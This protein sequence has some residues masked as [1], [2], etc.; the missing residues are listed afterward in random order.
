MR[1]LCP[2]FPPIPLLLGHPISRA[3]VRKIKRLILV[4]PQT[5][6]VYS[7]YNDPLV[8]KVPS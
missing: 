5:R 2:L 1:P 7:L 4:W 6:L 8:T 3:V